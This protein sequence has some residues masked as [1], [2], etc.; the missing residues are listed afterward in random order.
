MSFKNEKEESI[1]EIA[2]L[3]NNFIF[4]KME[5]KKFDARKGINTIIDSS[6]W[7]IRKIL[8]ETNFKDSFSQS[9][10]IA[11]EIVSR[12]SSRIDKANLLHIII[13]CSKT[14]NYVT[15]EKNK[16]CYYDYME[17]L[18]NVYGLRYVPKPNEAIKEDIVQDYSS[19]VVNRILCGDLS[20]HDGIRVF[21][22]NL[23]YFATNCTAS[24]DEFLTISHQ[25]EKILKELINI[26]NEIKEE[27]HAIPYTSLVLALF[28]VIYSYA[29]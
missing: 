14:I 19:I 24:K 1:K 21:S 13:G 16:L 28:T 20:I 25:S 18:K 6:T 8:S 2:L 29:N 4:D 23:L 17:D 10:E 12:M 7:L 3:Y 5:N 11:E 15:E 26:I 22:Y 27:I 9:T